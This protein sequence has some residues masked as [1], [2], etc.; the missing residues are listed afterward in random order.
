MFFS[1]SC[2][3]LYSSLCSCFFRDSGGSCVA[4][5]PTCPT[6]SWKPMCQ[7]R[8]RQGLPGLTQGPA[9]TYVPPRGG[10]RNPEFWRAPQAWW[11]YDVWNVNVGARVVLGI[12]GKP[13][14]TVVSD[15]SCPFST[16]SEPG[17]PPGPATGFLKALGP[18]STH[19][20]GSTG[21]L[22]SRCGFCSVLRPAGNGFVRR[23]PATEGL[24]T[25][26]LSWL[27]SV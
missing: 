12:P 11:N 27:I 17:W 14:C 3:S 21:H 26:D 13:W 23:Q 7:S 10:E 20:S 4:S 1:S 16:P 2:L 8:T 22:S 9:V 19:S 5:L 24:Q 25:P 18:P 6:S 15:K